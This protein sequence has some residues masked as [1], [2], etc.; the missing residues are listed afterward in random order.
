M[1]PSIEGEWARKRRMMSHG[2][3]I[4]LRGG[5]LDPR[6]WPGRYALMIASHRWL[7]YAGPFLHLLSLR[8]RLSRALHAPLLAAAL[9]A[10][11]ARLR[12]LL[13]ARYYV[14]T[15]ASIAAGLYDWLRHG[16]EAGWDAAEGTR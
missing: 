6:G 14:L 13:V 2:W 5:L 3:P 9:L 15:Q 16:T 4:V 8:S 10:P 11:R 12:P 7:R 1:V